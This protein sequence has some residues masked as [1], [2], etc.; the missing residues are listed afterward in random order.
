MIA[1]SRSPGYAAFNEWLNDVIEIV[2][3]I[4]EISILSCDQIAI[5]DHEVW[6]LSV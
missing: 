3:R 6:L 4:V 1:V 5:E 2:C